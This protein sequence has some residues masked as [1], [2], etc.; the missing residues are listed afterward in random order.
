MAAPNC[1]HCKVPMKSYDTVKKS[2]G[3]YHRYKCITRWCDRCHGNCT[4][5]LLAP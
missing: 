4:E 3:I 2:D 1:P 5:T